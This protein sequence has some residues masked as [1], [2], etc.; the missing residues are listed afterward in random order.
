MTAKK[1][2]VKGK[3]IIEAEM[4]KS[5]GYCIEHCPKNAIELAEYYNTKGYHPAVPSGENCNGCGICA[6]VCPEGIIEVWRE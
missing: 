4:C 3:I 1:K 6:V 5:C 2:A